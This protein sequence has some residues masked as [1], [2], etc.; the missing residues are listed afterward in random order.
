MAE[1]SGEVTHGPIQTANASADGVPSAPTSDEIRSQIEHT[2]A[3]MSDTIDAIQTRLSPKR[4]LPDAKDTV[5][6]ATVGR[7]KR[8]TQRANGSG[9]RVLQK[10]Q[11]NPMPAAL[12]ATAAVGLLVRALMN[13]KRR[14]QH[15][16]TPTMPVQHEGVSQ[17]WSTS[18]TIS[19]GGRGNRRLL[20]A[21]GAGVACWAI[22]RAQT[23]IRSGNE[24][25][26]AAE[27]QD[28]GL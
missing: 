8:L 22:W 19:K 14:R 27:P 23:A 17:A 16:T 20:A 6:E 13:G 4:V 10:V 25:S 7:V 3:E 24:Q 15:G 5:A 11:D 18:E 21:A 9:A 12:L 1:S 28:G 2:R 26:I